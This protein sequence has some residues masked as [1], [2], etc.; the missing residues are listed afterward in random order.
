ML[1]GSVVKTLYDTDSTDLVTLS[2]QSSIPKQYQV[3]FQN[4]KFP[5]KWT[6]SHSARQDIIRILLPSVPASFIHIFTFSDPLNQ[7]HRCLSHQ[8]LT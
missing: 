6:G 3:W 1:C 7:V 4:H 2:P 5:V 8:S